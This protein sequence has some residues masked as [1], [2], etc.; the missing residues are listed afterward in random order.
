MAFPLTPPPPSEPCLAR[1]LCV[2]LRLTQRFSFFRCLR[3]DSVLLT[4][5]CFF[6]FERVPFS[7]HLLVFYMHLRCTPVRDGDR[8]WAEICNSHFSRALVR[9]DL[10]GEKK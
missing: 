6:Y 4:L 10:T 5:F 8:C 1:E 2:R 7:F 9:H 3:F